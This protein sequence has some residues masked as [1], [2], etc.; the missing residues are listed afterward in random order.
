VDE[1]VEL[2][3]GGVDTWECDEMGHL[4]V[5]WYLS[6]ASRGLSA[7]AAA[8][9]MAE[10]FSPR[11]ASTLLVRDQHVRFLREAKAGVALHMTGG[12][13][14]IDDTGA[15]LLQ[16]LR[17]SDSGEPC[18]TFVTRVEHVTSEEARPFAWSERR[19]AAAEALKVET[20][21]YAAARGVT[22]D[23]V[24]SSASW[25]RADDLGLPQIARSAVIP[26]DCDVFGRLSPEAVMNV[27]W[28]GK[29]QLFLRDGA[30]DD[31]GRVML[32][33]RIMHLRHAA[34]G[35]QLSL[36]SGLRDADDKTERYVHWLLDPVSG[37]PWASAEAVTARFDL[38]ARRL[39]PATDAVREAQARWTV[40]GLAL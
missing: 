37:K 7:L 15:R 16:V 10:A 32:E 19:R 35:A 33:I 11:A 29:R 17:H 27:I 9:G 20:P 36:R 23:P 40:P 26:A 31:V 24:E 18:A 8:L 4:N 34:A 39:A 38:A 21:A 22:V 13:L 14:T 2:W 30:G 5:V 12:V 25:E 28:Q 1:G 3:R 6:R